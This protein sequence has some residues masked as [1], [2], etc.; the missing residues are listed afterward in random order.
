MPRVEEHAWRSWTADALHS[1]AALNG[2]LDHPARRVAV[3]GEDACG[4]R[5][6]VG[7]DA[8]APVELAARLHQRRE[9]LGDVPWVEV[10]GR[11]GNRW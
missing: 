7:A 10:V 9:R 2:R 3:E 8:H 11:G 1:A 4:E 5:A 6:V